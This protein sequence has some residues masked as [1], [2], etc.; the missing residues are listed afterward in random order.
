MSHSAIDVAQPDFLAAQ[1]AVSRHAG[2][3]NDRQFSFTGVIDKLQ[4]RFLCR[5]A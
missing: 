3:Q 2:A 4:I 5:C 1:R